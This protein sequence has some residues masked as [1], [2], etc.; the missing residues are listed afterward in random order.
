MQQSKKICSSFIFGKGLCF[1]EKKKFFEKNYP[2]KVNL[3]NELLKSEKHGLIWN[4]SIFQSIFP[5]NKTYSSDKFVNKLCIFL[6]KMTLNQVWY[7]AMNLIYICALAF[8]LF[9]NS[10]YFHPTLRRTK[11]NRVEKRHALKTF[12][13]Q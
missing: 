1:K 11:H 13:I 10:V 12:I 3:S 2:E 8:Q 7:F 5:H 4:V 6:L 9:A